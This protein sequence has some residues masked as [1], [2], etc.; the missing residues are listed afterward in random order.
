MECAVSEFLQFL[1]N[2]ELCRKQWLEAEQLSAELNSQ[3]TERQHDNEALETKLIHARSVVHFFSL[4]ARYII[5]SW[6]MHWCTVTHA[7]VWSV[8][9]VHYITLLHAQSVVHWFSLSSWYI[10][11]SWYMHSHSCICLDCHLRSLRQVDT[12]TC[13][14]SRALVQTISPVH[15][16]KLTRA[17]PVVH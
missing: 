5:P 6:Y 12:Y 3:C 15:Y 17:R 2:Q 13:T 14:A 16:A 8:R 7:L 11:P 9:L 1:A 10:T 4:S